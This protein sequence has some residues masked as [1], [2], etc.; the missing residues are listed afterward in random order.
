MKKIKWYSLK[1]KLLALILLSMFVSFI[2]SLIVSYFDA[3]QE[4]DELFDAQMSQAAQTLLVF[5]ENNV[6]FYTK[7]NNSNAKKI[8][9]NILKKLKIEVYHKYQS[10]LYFQIWNDKNQLILIS[11]NAPLDAPL[12]NIESF[13]TMN[14]DSGHWRLYTQWN[15][16][17]T[18]QVQIKE[19]HIIRDNI[20]NKILVEL[21]YTLLSSLPFLALF[22][23]LSVKTAFSTLNH[24]VTQV[25]QREPKQLTALEITTAPKEIK[26]LIEAINNLFLRVAAT[27]IK[28]REFTANAAHELRTPLA[29]LK[30][31]IQVLQN[32][33]NNV[34]QTEKILQVNKIE[35]GINRSIHLVEQMLILSRLE[36]N[37][38]YIINK[39]INLE[40][41]VTDVCAEL[42]DLIFADDF[43]FCFTIEEN[44]KFEI[45]GEEEWIKI[46]LR[47]L[48]KNAMNYTPKAG[49]IIVSL[50]LV[51]HQNDKFNLTIADSGI[52][53][54]DK[55]KLQVFNRFYQV[56]NVVSNEMTTTKM[57]GCGLGL[58]I[59]KYIADLH[60]FNIELKDAKIGGLEVKISG[61]LL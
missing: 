16:D 56:N 37:T 46:L 2:L 49:K 34:E 51:K 12:T 30:T 3:H 32:N 7:N 17:K 36:N 38:D 47:N 26:P 40:N 45:L 39:K 20:I 10:V 48:I 44:K 35:Q 43:D 41:V 33:I 21:F 24:I 5:A 55:E 13:S 29:V 15:S 52:G 42:A 4:I 1:L 53:I 6:D 59:V 18:L 9:N 14:D 19:N 22:I 58:A 57:K 27:I 11:E 60:N 25:Q 23:W 50:E 54:P 28:E 31:Q 61:K 8:D